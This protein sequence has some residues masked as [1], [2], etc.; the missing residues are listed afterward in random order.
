MLS[1][2]CFIKASV[3]Y[4][5]DTYTYFIENIFHILFNIISKEKNSLIH[6]TL[7]ES[8]LNVSKVDIFKSSYLNTLDPYK[9]HFCNE[10][11]QKSLFGVFLS[12]LKRQI[13]YLM[14]E[15]YN[16]DSYCRRLC[17]HIFKYYIEDVRFSNLFSHP[18]ISLQN[19]FLHNNSIQDIC[20][21]SNKNDM[22]VNLIDRT[23]SFWKSTVQFSENSIILQFFQLFIEIINKFK[24]IFLY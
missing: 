9:S 8:L 16:F 23:N 11:K 15:H 22:K 18:S 21:Y 6:Y 12:F 3:I 10:I 24:I 14:N 19:Y 7:L 4:S 1:L 13:W 2:D 20:L 17:Y 5:T